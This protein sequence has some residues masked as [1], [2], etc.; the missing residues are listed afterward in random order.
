M[1][2]GRQLLDGATMAFFYF[3][4]LRSSSFQL[5]LMDSHHGLAIA[6]CTFMLTMEEIIDY[7]R[8]LT[9]DTALPI[10]LFFKEDEPCTLPLPAR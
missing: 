1:K 7:F 2:N 6:P 4:A 5:N 9:F 10:C 8:S 3:L